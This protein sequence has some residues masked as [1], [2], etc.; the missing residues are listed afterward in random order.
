MSY[1]PSAGASEYPTQLTIQFSSFPSLSSQP[2]SK[3]TKSHYRI[4]KSIPKVSVRNIVDSICFRLSLSCK[5]HQRVRL[6]C[7]LVPGQPIETFNRLFDDIT[8]L[9]IAREHHLPAFES[10]LVLQ[11]QTSRSSVSRTGGRLPAANNPPPS[12]LSSLWNTTRRIDSSFD[13]RYKFLTIHLIG[14]FLAHIPQISV[15][16]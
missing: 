6:A 7:P 8:L 12:L 4:I 14:D 13:L 11:Q 9:S 15:S 16:R 3:T 1:P 10:S 2:T 5:S